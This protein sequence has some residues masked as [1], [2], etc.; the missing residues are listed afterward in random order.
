MKTITWRSFFMVLFGNILIGLAVAILRVSALGTDPFT[1][2]NLGLSSLFDLS[3]GMYQ[4]FFNIILLAVVI[5]FYRKSLGIGTI[6]NMVGIGFI[7]DFFVLCMS[8][9]TDDLSHLGIRLILMAVAF[10]IACFGVALYITPELGV[11]PYDAMAF[12]IENVSKQ[13]IPFP[14]AR[15]TTD[16]LC[17]A[18]GFSFG[19][20]VG[21]A[22]VIFAF[23]T[24]PLVQYFRRHIAEPMLKQRGTMVPVKN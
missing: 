7:S 9:I 10:V 5:P 24:G 13:K 22:T 12:V 17:V 15:I 23:F 14:I 18:I 11:A 21:I 20:I 6:V 4:L 1:T 16:V 2:I 3:F 19:A 8:I